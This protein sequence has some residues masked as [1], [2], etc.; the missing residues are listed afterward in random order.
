LRDLIGANAIKNG[1]T[2]IY[3]FPGYVL[4]LPIVAALV[5]AVLGIVVIRKHWPLRVSLIL[6][7]LAVFVGGLMAP[8]MWMDR[9][10]LDEEKLEQ[11]TGFWWSPTIKGFRLAEARFVQIV[12]R[13]DSKGR[14]YEVW[15]VQMKDG[16]VQEIDPGDL[17]ERNGKDITDRLGA[18]GIEVRR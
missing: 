16:R 15:Q 18:E 11:T 9:V 7:G 6:F 17:W 10:V 12:T 4:A 13:R 2:M 5:L 14:K 3:K 1:H 8:A